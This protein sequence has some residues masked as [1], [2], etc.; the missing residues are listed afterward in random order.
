[1]TLLWFS[2]ESS[3]AAALNGTALTE[4]NI[5]AVEHISKA[6]MYKYEALC[7]FTAA[8]VLDNYTTVRNCPAC[9]S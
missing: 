7:C 4:K 3:V 8:E 5:V 6:C 1:M 2:K 9:S